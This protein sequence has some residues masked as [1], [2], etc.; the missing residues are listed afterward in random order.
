MNMRVE[1]KRLRLIATLVISMM[2]FGMIG[3]APASGAAQGTGPAPTVGEIVVDSFDCVAG[4]IMFHVPVTNLPAAPEGS[5]GFDYP[6]TYGFESFYGPNGTPER[7]TQLPTYNPPVDQSPFTGDV[8]LSFEFIPTSNQMGV[9]PGTEPISSIDLLVRV[10]YPGQF[11]NS[12][13]VT[14]TST[15]TYTVDCSDEGTPD[16]GFVARLVAV[17]VRILSEILNR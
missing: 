8:S 5:S 6:L 7:P 16:G 12:S 11:D 13:L 10:G 9:P 3:L 2:L 1:Q 14:G 17:L 15:T 4:V